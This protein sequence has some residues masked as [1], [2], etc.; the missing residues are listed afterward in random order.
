MYDAIQPYLSDA[1]YRECMRVAEKNRALRA[2]TAAGRL[3]N[4]YGGEPDETGEMSIGWGGSG[5]SGQRIRY[6]RSHWRVDTLPEHLHYDAPSHE[7]RE[8][9]AD[10]I[11]NNHVPPV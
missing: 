5:L 2:R 9:I 1:D 10:Y 8:A 4:K 7:G 11:L 3:A 6:G